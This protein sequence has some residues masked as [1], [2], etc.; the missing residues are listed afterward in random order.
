MGVI[1]G[2]LIFV[3]ALVLFIALFLAN[4]FLNLSWSLEYETLQ[5]NILEHAGG[6]INDTGIRDTIKTTLPVMEFYCMTHN[7]YIFTEGDFNFEIPCSVVNSGVDNLINFGV[8][9]L[10]FQIYYND[11][12]CEFWDCVKNSDIPFVLIS[13]KA[14]DYWHSKFRLA[15]WV[16]LLSFGLMFLFSRDKGWTLMLTGIFVLVSAFLFRKFDWFLSI[17]P[18]LAFFD[19]LNIF[20]ARSQGIFIIM[21][22]IGGTLLLVGIA[23]KFFK[24]SFNVFKVFRKKEKKKEGLTK[25]DIKAA[26]REE[27]DKGTK[28]KGTPLGVPPSTERRGK[29]ATKKIKRKA[30]KAEKGYKDLTKKK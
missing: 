17:L 15:C 25:D 12:D 11:Y 27:M 20:F 28:K 14:K 19:V 22:F 8:E 7:N 3:L 4:G 24:I 1:R 9:T 18:D 13:E 5:P 26:V 30:K 23:F 29:R 2:A 21:M 16:A 10:I 6:I